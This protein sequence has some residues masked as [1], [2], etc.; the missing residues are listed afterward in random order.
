MASAT[1]FYNALSVDYDLF[2]DWPAR[3]AYER[4]LL[5]E[6]LRRLGAR[7]VLD[8][9]CGT[10]QHAIALARA[11]YRV[12]GV[13]VSPEMIARARENARAAGVEARFAVRGFGELAGLGERFD[14]LLCLGNSLP[15]LTHPAALAAG[16]ADFYGVLADGGGAILQQRNFDRVLARQERY[17]PPQSARRGADEWLFVRFYD[18]DGADLRFNMLRLHRRDGEPWEWRAEATPLR[19]WRAEELRRALVEAGF[20]EPEARGNLAGELY[21]PATSGDLVLLA[22]RG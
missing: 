20:R 8:V 15:H 10:G 2:V 4:P 12:L 9:A 16:L 11:G 7:T 6:H 1:E 14:A 5:E 22:S 21:D 13:D 18:F 3:L 19:A 17:M